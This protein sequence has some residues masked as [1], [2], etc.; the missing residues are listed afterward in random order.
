MDIY[1]IKWTRLQSEIFRLLCIKSGQILNLREIAR[2]LKVSPTAVSNSLPLLEK[3]EMIRIKK[4]KTIKLLSIEL[5]REN[6][7]VINLKRVENLRLI[8]ESGLYDFL[9]NELPG[10]TIMLFGSYSNG[11]DSWIGDKDE[12]RSD[13]DIAVIGAK[14]KKL[15]LKELNKLFEKTININ[16]YSSWNEIHRNLK[17][18]I[19]N[20]ILLKGGIEL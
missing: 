4:S 8:Y 18:N 19:L 7:K 11:S 2:A 9:F 3:E 12:N 5:N 10:R 20:G 15:N 16:F 13:I 14:E 17:N 1:K 6:P